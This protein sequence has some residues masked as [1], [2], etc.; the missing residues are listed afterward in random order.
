MSY[1]CPC[2][3]STAGMGVAQLIAWGVD[4]AAQAATT[5]A[6][7]AAGEA[8][9]NERAAKR[10]EQAALLRLQAERQATSGAREVA[11]T[12]ATSA[13]EAAR[14][15]IEAQERQNKLIL[16]GAAGLGVVALAALVL[17]R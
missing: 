9:K 7:V 16:A 3:H 4:A 1:S 17:L 5:T 8:K 14:I 12:R 11:R 10:G 2:T 6:S 15:A 13:R